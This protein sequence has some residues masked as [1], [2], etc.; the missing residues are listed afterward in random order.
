[1][2]CLQTNGVT[3][4]MPHN[5]AFQTLQIFRDIIALCA[6]SLTAHKVL[7]RLM[8]RFCGI[9]SVIM[10]RRRWQWGYPWEVLRRLVSSA[11]PLSCLYQRLKYFQNKVRPSVLPRRCTHRET[12]VLMHYSSVAAADLAATCQTQSGQF[13]FRRPQ[14]GAETLT[15]NRGVVKANQ[16]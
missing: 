1:M 13:G 12:R 4:V 6:W 11:P 2:R 15:F 5:A 9:L 7:S 8:S 10:A 16:N 14:S 3:L